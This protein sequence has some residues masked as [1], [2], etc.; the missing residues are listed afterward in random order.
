[1]LNDLLKVG[2]RLVACKNGW[3]AQVIDASH[4]CLIFMKKGEVF[5]IVEHIQEHFYLEAKGSRFRVRIDQLHY[6]E[7]LK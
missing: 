2:N 3:K 7:I 6:F 4:E 1:M 5:L